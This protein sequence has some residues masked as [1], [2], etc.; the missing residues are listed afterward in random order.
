MTGKTEEWGGGL[1]GCHNDD[2]DCCIFITACFCPAVVYGIN[3]SIIAKGNEDS[4]YH[5]LLPCITHSLV[6]SFLSTFALGACWGGPCANGGCSG[7]PL[8]LACCLR[9]NHRRTA[10]WLQRAEE[11][12]AMSMLK[13]TFCWGCSLAQV[14]R[15]FNLQKKREDASLP[16]TAILKGSNLTGWL[17]KNTMAA[18]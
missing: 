7:V 8:P 17:T 14:N 18:V 12:E 9:Y 4:T 10:I 16:T 2:H 3:Y 13:E 11:A 1:L 6:D 15:Q 5:C